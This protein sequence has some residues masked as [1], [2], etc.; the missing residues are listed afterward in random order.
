MLIITLTALTA[1]VLAAQD[2]TALGFGAPDEE[3]VE[4]MI[5][6]PIADEIDPE[7]GFASNAFP[8]TIP[9]TEWHQEAWIKDNCLRCHE[10]GV[11]EAPVI[12]HRG[13]PPILLRA[14]CRTC[15][16][17][18]PG[19]TDVRPRVKE[20]TPFDD[21]AFPPV[22]PASASHRN[23][24]TIEDCLMCHETGVQGAPIVVHKDMPRILLKA[25]CRSCHV[26]IRSLDNDLL[27]PAGTE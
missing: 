19:N 25:K 26:Q 13:L 9:D 1:I 2:D 14:K 18:I 23:A 6:E 27:E 11:E 24:W 4:D 21:N 12:V 8:P 16:I 15:H 17:L 10:T 20:E 5:V 22:I 3:A 7:T